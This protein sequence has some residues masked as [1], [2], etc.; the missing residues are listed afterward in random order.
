MLGATGLAQ[1]AAPFA[2]A[3][4]DSSTSAPRVWQDPQIQVP[5]FK[6]EVEAK[7]VKLTLWTFVDTHARWFKAMGEAYKSQVNPDFELEVVQTAGEAHHSKLLVS[8]Q[9][10]GVGAPDLADIEQ[11]SFGSFMKLQSGML[12][13]TDKLKSGGYLDQLVATRESLY[14]IQDQIYG[15]E[16][17]LAPVV[18]YYR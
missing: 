5:D 3:T 8:M 16:H 1:W 2:V 12:D 14:T 4:G 17:A 10:G 15:V 11:G 13:L 7:P 9:S 6:S 18:L